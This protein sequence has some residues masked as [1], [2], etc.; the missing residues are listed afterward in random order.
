MQPSSEPILSRCSNTTRDAKLVDVLFSSALDGEFV[1]DQLTGTFKP[2]DYTNEA[3]SSSNMPS[4]IDSNKAKY[5]IPEEVKARLKALERQAIRA[6]EAGNSGK[7]IAMF[8][9]ILSD[10]PNYSSAFNN[11][12]QVHRLMGNSSEALRDLDR[13]IEY[14]QEKRV[15]GQAYTQKAIILRSKGDQDGAYYNFSMG[16]RFGNEVAAMA[17]PKENPYAKLCGKMVSEAM[18]QLVVP[19]KQ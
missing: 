9:E 16:A 10:H 8:S 19:N 17:A 11:R 12:A 15:L 13:A 2:H 6:A 5:K 7:A 3:S 18:R 1:R 4:I 14:A